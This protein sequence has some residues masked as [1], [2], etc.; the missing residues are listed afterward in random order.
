MCVG[1]GGGEELH[2]R[3]ESNIAFH[4]CVLLI[5]KLFFTLRFKKKFCIISNYFCAQNCGVRFC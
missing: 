4:F 2:I 3:L 1:G 5:M